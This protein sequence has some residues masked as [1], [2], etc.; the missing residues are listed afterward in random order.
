MWSGI[1][2]EFDT[3]ATGNAQTVAALLRGQAAGE[4]EYRAPTDEAVRSSGR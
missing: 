2:G 3:A 4:A 1:S